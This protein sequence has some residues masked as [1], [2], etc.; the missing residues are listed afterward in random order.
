[1]SE[2]TVQLDTDLFTQECRALGEASAAAKLRFDPKGPVA[3]QQAYESYKGPRNPQSYFVRKVL[4]LR[5][6]AVKRGMLVDKSVTPEFLE[7]I[8]D[9]R[10]PVTHEEL[11]FDS[12]GQDK[13]NP[14]IDRLVN[15]VS[16]IAGNICVLSQRANRAKGEKSFEEVAAIASAGEPCE[17]LEPVEWMRMCSLMYG[18]WAYAYKKSDPYLLPLAALPKPGMFTSTSQVVQL[19][20][21][22]HFS[23]GAQSTGFTEF[24]TKLTHDSGQPQGVFLTL[25][26]ALMEALSTASYPGN[27]WLHAPVFNA[28]EQWYLAC[29]HVIGTELQPRL[30][31]HQAQAPYPLQD[32]AWDLIA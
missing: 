19:L 21:T 22:R 15:E 26:D 17:R 14:S 9:S 27:A 7:R 18:A 8:S 25:R 30:K 29:Q 32:Q 10:C 16:Y 20:L 3:Y 12:K 1:M 11:A 24:W 31:Q 2:S 6:N 28:F 23:P 5:L 4:G 13:L